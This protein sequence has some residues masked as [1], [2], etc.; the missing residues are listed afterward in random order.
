MQS[1]SKGARQKVDTDRRGIRH[2]IWAVRGAA[3]ILRSGFI[4]FKTRCIVGRRLCCLGVPQVT[5]K[6]PAPHLP[7]RF[8]RAAP[9]SFGEERQVGTD[10]QTDWRTSATQHPSAVTR[11]EQVE[12]T[13]LETSC[14]RRQTKL[15]QTTQRSEP[16]R[17]FS[18]RLRRATPVY[19][20]LVAPQGREQTCWW[21]TQTACTRVNYG[22]GMQ[23]SA[24]CHL[25]RQKHLNTPSISLSGKQRGHLGWVGLWVFWQEQSRRNAVMLQWHP[26]VCSTQRQ[27]DMPPQ[28]LPALMDVLPYIK[29]MTGKEYIYIERDCTCQ[30]RLHKC[31]ITVHVCQFISIFAGWHIM[32]RLDKIYPLFSLRRGS[33][34]T[35]G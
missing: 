10:T 35:R 1:S 31:T 23:S 28:N 12:L 5:C 6:K 32:I 2:R 30:W 22:N 34:S 27:A 15:C 4:R 7:D 11:E 29:Y 9:E 25:T 18:E 24:W 19:R 8:A 20:L 16:A 13:L 17:S 3:S 33:S 14:G 26:A 21:Y